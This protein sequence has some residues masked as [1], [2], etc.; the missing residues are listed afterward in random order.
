MSIIWK[1]W[2]FHSVLKFHLGLA[3]PSWNFNSLYRV[4]IFTCNCNVILKRSLLFNRDDISTRLTSWNF[5]PGW[6][7]PNNQLLRW[8]LGN[9]INKTIKT[10]NHTWYNVN[11]FVNESINCLYLEV[12]KVRQTV[13]L[14]IRFCWKRPIRSHWWFNGFHSKKCTKLILAQPV[15]NTA[16]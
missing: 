2:N 14:D 3:K 1:I 12:T 11:H 5:N 4:E 10:T 8:R 16:E 15:C 13:R 6:K 9:I 7:S